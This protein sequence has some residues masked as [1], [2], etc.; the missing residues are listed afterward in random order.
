VRIK[1][2]ELERAYARRTS[3]FRFL[4]PTVHTLTASISARLVRHR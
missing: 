1:F 2:I 3:R 4:E